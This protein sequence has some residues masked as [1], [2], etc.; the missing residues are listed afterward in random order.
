[1]KKVNYLVGISVC[2][3]ALLSGCIS[4]E[5]SDGVKAIRMRNNFV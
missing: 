1:M 2:A 5:E 3:L 4:N